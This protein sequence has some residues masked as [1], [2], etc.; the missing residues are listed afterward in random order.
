MAAAGMRVPEKRTIKSNLSL[1]RK[2]RK[3]GEGKGLDQK[4]HS[5]YITTPQ[6]AFK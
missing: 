1:D 2:L 4:I 3:L 5:C 6:E